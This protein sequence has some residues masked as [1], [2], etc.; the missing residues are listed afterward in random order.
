MSL[1]GFKQEAL[2]FVDLILD[3][4]TDAVDW[5]QR[6]ARG[7]M[8]AANPSGWEAGLDTDLPV[9]CAPFEAPTDDPFVARQVFRLNAASLCPMPISDV[10][11]DVVDHGEGQWQALIARRNLVEAGRSRDGAG[12]IW[13][14]AILRGAAALSAR[15]WQALGWIVSIGLVAT[16]LFLAVEN[17]NRRI[18]DTLDGQTAEQRDLIAA[19]ETRSNGPIRSGERGPLAIREARDALNE[20]LSRMPG[21][22]D[23]E[24]IAI[25][26]GALIVTLHLP[27]SGTAS[28]GEAALS[29]LQ[30]SMSARY[31]IIG[32]QALAALDRPRMAVT[33]WRGE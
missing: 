21:G 4:I 26:E 10:I 25:R 8:V 15:R 13:G 7:G 3:L 20:V 33:L 27:L 23:A 18:G 11:W 24:A 14:G 5:A 9:L 32:V 29:D 17:L 12:I 1:T 6:I 19:L 2:V 16:S 30:A 22:W 28:G 31:Q